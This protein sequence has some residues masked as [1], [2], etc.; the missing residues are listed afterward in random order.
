MSDII[1]LLPDSVANQIAAGEV[2]QRPASVLK[3]L[4]ENSIDANANNIIIQIKNA[5]RTLIQVTDNGKGMSETDARLAFERHATSKI[6]NVSDIYALQSYGFRGEALAS[7]A[8]VAQ[9]ELQTRRK[10]DEL[11]TLIEIEG[12]KVIRQ[13][14]V[15]CEEG[16][17]IRVKNLFFNV[18]ARRRFLKSDNV[19]KIHLLNEFYRI[20]LV[21]PDIRFSF[22][23]DKEEIFKLLPSPLKLRIE[24]IFGKGTKRKWEQQLLPIE[25]NTPLVK[26][27]GYVGRPEFALKS[28][29]QY[30]FVNARYMR[31]PYFHK[32]VI[33][34]YSQMI[35]PEENPNY[36]IYLYVA[37]E[38]IDV[39]IHPAKT[40]IKFENEQ[41][42][43][44]ILLATVRE[45]LGKYNVIPSI[46]FNQEDAID[47]PII[48]NNEKIVPPHTVFN[49]N[50]NPF[51][52]TLINKRPPLNWE[53][54]YRNFEKK[55]E[56]KP[57]SFQWIENDITAYAS[58]ASSIIA[59]ETLDSSHFLQL[60]T[61]YI[62]TAVKSGLLVIHQHKAHVRILYDLYLSQIKHQKSSSQQLLFPEILEL[63]EHEML[64]F[65]SIKNDLSN[66][67]FLFKSVGKNAFEIFGIPGPLDKMNIQAFIHELI[68]KF[69]VKQSISEEDLH[70]QIALSMAETSA[71]K[72]GQKLT[73]EEMTDLVNRLFATEEPSFSPQG[74]KILSIIPMEEFDSQF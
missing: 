44:S 12:S 57:T 66:V 16:T 69:K 70:Q 46:N 10:E 68:E 32:A 54:L 31:H 71:I 48:G 64:Y 6:S 7:I 3:E 67:G 61:K 52:N 14:S 21:Y 33:S 60:K 18:P 51:E 62:L 24:N 35:R 23:D 30:F 27:E 37:P 8:A 65:S 72:T 55:E 45:T 11:G 56:S 41:A 36:F 38:T 50:F 26:I 58:S 43:W 63:S 74:E 29:Y 40:E 42:I 17:T 28:A 13:E 39:N 34:A 49:P 19:E 2:I 53:T 59:E 20:A 73:Q 22:F 47:L 25:T 1:H 15:L 9:V 5:G 4:I